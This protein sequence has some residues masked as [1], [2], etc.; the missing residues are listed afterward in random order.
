MAKSLPTPESNI[1][2][3]TVKKSRQ[4]GTF[5]KVRLRN[6]SIPTECVHLLYCSACEKHNAFQLLIVEEI[7]ERPQAS[8]LSKWIAHKV[9]VVT[10]IFSIP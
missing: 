7:I 1:I 3:G 2:E 6:K 8:I 5:R 9:W 10:K 4:N